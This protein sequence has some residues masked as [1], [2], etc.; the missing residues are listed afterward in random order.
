MRFRNE[1]PMGCEARLEN[2][3]SRPLFSAGDFNRKVDQTTL[4]F[5]MRPRFISIGLCMQDYKSLCAAVKISFTLVMI[6]TDDHTYTITQRQHFDQFIC[7]AQPAEPQMLQ[8]I[9]R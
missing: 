7:K 3:Y 5:G 4:V 1:R 8:S 9:L 2:I 6:Q